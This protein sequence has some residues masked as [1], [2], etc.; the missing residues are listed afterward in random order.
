MLNGDQMETNVSYEKDTSNLSECSL[1]CGH[2]HNVEL[3][4]E[5]HHKT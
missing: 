5:T 1:L 4:G 3:A 2:A